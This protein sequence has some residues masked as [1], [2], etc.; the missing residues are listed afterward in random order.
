[1]ENY[2]ITFLEAFQTLRANPTREA[3]PP[4]SL[5]NLEAITSAFNINVLWRELDVA[6]LL[7]GTHL[8]MLVSFE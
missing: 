2:A 8:M 5:H 4:Q 6:P 1:M 3:F 7:G